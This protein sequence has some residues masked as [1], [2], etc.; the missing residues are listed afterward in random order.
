MSDKE[1]KHQDLAEAQFIDVNLHQAHFENVNMAAMTIHNANLSQAAITDANI[2]GMTIFGLRIDLLIEEELDRRDPMRVSMRMRDRHNIEDVKGV[3]NALNRL[4]SEF[5]SKLRNS[6]SAVLNNH[7][8]PDRWSA[9][10]HVR[11]LV[12]AEELYLNR[13][14]LRNTKPLSSLGVLPP[15]LYGNAAFTNVGSTPSEDLEYI[16]DAWQAVHREMETWIDDADAADLQKG[17]QDV[18]F[19][20]QTIGDAL[21]TL[22]S[23]DLEHIRMAERAIEDSIQSL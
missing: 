17:I 18:S 2:Y 19:G 21:Q 10:E 8:G 15:F 1:F 11:H 4:R 7:P 13:W 14:I 3:I 12:F 5:I 9:L 22:A 16:L 6:S 20:Q 23:H